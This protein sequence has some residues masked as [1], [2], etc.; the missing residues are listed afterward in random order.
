MFRDPGV[1]RNSVFS[2]PSGTPGSLSHSELQVHGVTQNYSGTQ[3]SPEQI[4]N[5][6]VTLT[7]PGTGIHGELYREPGV[8]GKSGFPESRGT[9]Q[10]SRSHSE[11]LRNPGSFINLP[12]FRS[13]SELLRGCWVTRKPG[14]SEST[15]TPGYR[16]H[17]ELRIPG[18]TRNRGFPESPGGFRVS[19]VTR[20]TTVSRSH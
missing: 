7:V 19:A 1:T 8:T 17:P 20:R 2:E 16:S 13:H 6:G 14:F 9:L 15:G 10:T 3:E 12:E 18:F 4:R 5:P 11:L